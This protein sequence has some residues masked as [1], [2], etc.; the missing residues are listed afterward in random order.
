MPDPVG[1]RRR[2]ADRPGMPAISTRTATALGIVAVPA[3]RDVDA[4][5][6]WAGNRV[7]VGPALATGRPDTD[8]SRKT[9]T[10]VA[11]AARGS[12]AGVRGLLST[13]VPTETWVPNVRAWGA[14]PTTRD[15]PPRRG[16]GAVLSG[17]VVVSTP[18]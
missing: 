3:A 9:P 12:R 13:E 11:G 18:T 2:A 1:M 16:V 15:P 6:T 5:P 8:R 17:L 14:A 10:P 7:R 4:V